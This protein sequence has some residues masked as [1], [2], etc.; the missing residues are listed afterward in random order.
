MA[1]DTHHDVQRLELLL[2]ERPLPDDLERSWRRQQGLLDAASML[3]HAVAVAFSLW[4]TS[5]LV[6]HF[7]VLSLPVVLAAPF[8]VG[9]LVVDAGRTR[10]ELFMLR[11]L[12]RRLQ[13]R[14]QSVGRETS[15]GVPLLR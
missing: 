3:S 2:T 11:R 8:V 1:F 14:L 15:T 13:Q 7:G 12:H 4:V 5:W 6:P 10:A 9:M